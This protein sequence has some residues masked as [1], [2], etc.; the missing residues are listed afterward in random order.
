MSPL[1]DEILLFQVLAMKKI[2]FDLDI[3]PYQIDIA[4]HVN[5]AVY[6]N[7][8]EIGRQ[9]LLD[10]VGMP[11]SKLLK[12][13]SVPTLTQTNITYKSPLS[14][15]DRVWIETWLTGLGSTSAIMHFN[16]YNADPSPADAENKQVL[17][18][19]GFQRGLF[20][21]PTSHRPKR[22]TAAEKSALMPYLDVPSVSKV[23]LL[24]KNTRFRDVLSRSNE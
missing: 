2:A 5:N 21:D 23:D 9:K 14:L 20:V 3:Y 10:A 12:Q 15:N 1:S 18:A 8:M 24:P 19:E 7:W 22:F 6:I 13:G 16:F 17:V 4:G 11:I